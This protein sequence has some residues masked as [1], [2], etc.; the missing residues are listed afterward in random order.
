[1]VDIVRESLNLLIFP[2]KLTFKIS[3]FNITIQKI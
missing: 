2:Y 1:M 3:N